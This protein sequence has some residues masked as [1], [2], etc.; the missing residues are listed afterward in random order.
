M[1]ALKFIDQTAAPIATSILLAA[2][3][4]AMIGFFASG[5]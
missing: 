1:S 2:L 5:F 4:I 3:P